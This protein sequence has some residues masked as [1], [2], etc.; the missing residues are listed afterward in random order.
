[1]KKIPIAFCFDTNMELPAGICITSLL[2]NAN[3]DTFYDIFILLAEDSLQIQNG[4]LNKLKHKYS[5]FNIT[6]RPI[7][8]QFNEAFEIRGITKAT[9]YRLLIP[10]VIPE[11]DKIM[12]HDVDIIFREDLSS[13][14]E[15][16]NLEGYYVAG[17][18]STG[19]LN[20]STYQKRIKLGLEPYEYILTGD[21]IFNSKLL[22]QDD[23]VS[24]FKKEV[25]SQNHE[26]QDQDVINIICKGKIKK[27]HPRFCFTYDMFRIAAN[28]INQNLF[29]KEELLQGEKI[30]IVHYNGPKPWKG[31]CPNFDIWWEYYRRSVFFDGKYYFDFFNDKV[32]EYDSLTLMKRIKILLRYFIN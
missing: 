28:N 22:R 20:P 16:T 8:Y 1:M 23:I 7:K 19:S 32:N 25:E 27:I 14:F 4:I 15:E 31:Y 13:I 26:F 21:I 10:E 9:Y 18:L 29:S 17:V 2:E 11:Y 6:Y 24:K 30:G 3:D 5:N 12:Y